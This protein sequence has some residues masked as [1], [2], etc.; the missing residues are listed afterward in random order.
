LPTNQADLDILARAMRGFTPGEEPSSDLIALVQ[1]R[2]AAVSEIYKRIIYHQQTQRSET[3]GDEFRLRAVVE[4]GG[5][6][7]NE[8]ILVRLAIDCPALF[9]IAQRADLGAHARRNL[10]RFFS[11]AMTSSERYAAVRGNPEALSRALT[12]FESSEYLTE[13]LVRHPEEITSLAGMREGGRQGSGYLFDGPFGRGPASGDPVFEY[14]A[15]SAAPHSE[16]LALLRRHY[17]HRVFASGAQDI[18][19]LRNVYHSLSVTTSTAEDAIAAAW[20]IAGR[21]NG[22]AVMGLGRVGSGEFDVLSDTDL[23]F[24]CEEGLDRVALTKSVEQFMHVLSAYTRDGMVCPVD[25]RLRPHG[26]EGELLV[27]PRQLESYFAREAQPWEALMYTKLRYL[28]GSRPLGERM[29]GCSRVLLNRFA[30]DAEF[31]RAVQEMRDR[32]EPEEKNLKLSA[33]GIY[34][35]DFLVSYLL[36]R[37]KARETGGSLR[38]R[39]WR[40]ASADLL[41]KSDAAVLDHAAEL[42]RTVEHVIRL[43]VGR[44]LKWLPPTEHARHMTERLVGNTLGRSFAGGLEKELE[45]SAVLVR[46]IYTR[47]LGTGA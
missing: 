21:P 2:M 26:A 4:A 6:D 14:V 32:L 34:D 8:Q 27:T 9:E 31:S 7:S 15:S 28:V 3:G 16:K 5:A 47:V 18:T 20:A 23:L 43:V 42:L 41:S 39:I 45:A 36:I 22:T 10:Y 11:S 35:I 33:G 1:K 25:T 19:E 17:R 12:L 44:A 40:C 37:G 30:E 29:H 13:I 24:V 46:A 38:D